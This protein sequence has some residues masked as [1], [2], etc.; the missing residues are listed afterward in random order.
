MDFFIFYIF[1]NVS[2]LVLAL[3]DIISIP[4]FTSHIVYSLGFCYKPFPKWSKSWS[5][6]EKRTPAFSTYQL[7]R[8]PIFC[9]IL[10]YTLIMV[11]EFMTGPIVPY[12]L[13]QYRMR[14]YL[15]LPPYG[16]HYFLA[17]IFSVVCTAYQKPELL[18]K[19]SPL[20]IGLGK[21]L[22]VLD[23]SVEITAIG[24]FFSFYGYLSFISLSEAWLLNVICSHM[25]CKKTLLS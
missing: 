23:F 25:D 20:A 9:Y 6:K 3:Y 12:M 2:A 4:Y 16:L 14:T 13:E 11:G 24:E 21:I 15:I 8:S 17:M 10:A 18:L 19:L 5:E 7:V 1:G 22:I